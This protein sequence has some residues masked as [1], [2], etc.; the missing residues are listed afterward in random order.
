MLTDS[1]VICD[2]PPSPLHGV[3]VYEDLIL[4]NDWPGEWG[5]MPACLKCFAIQALITEPLTVS[6]FR[7][8]FIH[9]AIPCQPSVRRRRTGC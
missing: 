8:R 6:E 7:A 9:G 2:G 4:P 1:C 5:G 3:P